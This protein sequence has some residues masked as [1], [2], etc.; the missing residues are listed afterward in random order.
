MDL[1]SLSRTARHTAGTLRRI[2]ERGGEYHVV[3][4][5]SYT[6]TD[7]GTVLGRVLRREHIAPPDAGAPVWRNLLHAVQRIEADPLPHALVRIT[8][9]GSTVTA[10]ADDEGFIHHRITPPRGLEPGWQPVT[11]SIVREGDATGEPLESVGRM[12]VPPP[13]A[14]FGVISDMDD[15]VLQSEVG[16]LLR[17][18]RLILLENSRTRLP[19]PGVAEFYRALHGDAPAGMGNPV[20]YVSSSPWN[21][22]DVIADFLE[23][24][25][26]PPGPLLLRDWE[27]RPSIMKHR[28][29]KKRMITEVLDSYPWLPFVLIGDSTQEDPEIYSAIV[30]E[31][32]ARIVAVYIRDV[33]AHPERRGAIMKLAAE[34]EAAG[35][36]LLLAEDTDLAVRHA[37]GRGLID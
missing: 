8:V 5:R 27:L 4:Y 10:R 9:G 31:Y 37:R 3:P 18:A 17:A 13:T 19:F 33:G 26:I 7:R 20:F 32:P 34:V 25:E 21:L 1:S 24:H 2:L 11:M 22:Y 29:H 12:L 35:S 6:G 23:A 30:H 14:R 15:T 16:N 28:S 36:S